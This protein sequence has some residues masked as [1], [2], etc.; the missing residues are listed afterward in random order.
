[1]GVRYGYRSFSTYHPALLSTDL[2]YHSQ[3]IF[4]SAE[5]WAKWQVGNRW[6]IFGFLPYQFASRKVSGNTDNHSGIGD[7]S[8]L[9]MYSILS[10]RISG[11]GSFLQNLQ[12][13]IG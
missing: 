8:F 4:Q 10:N 9:A 6:Q 1:I 13:G 7:V 11:S 2:P 12:A 5:V 3:E